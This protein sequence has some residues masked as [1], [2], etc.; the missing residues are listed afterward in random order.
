MSAS[1]FF[2]VRQIGQSCNKTNNQRPFFQFFLPTTTKL[3]V[4]TISAPNFTKSK[5]KVK[6]HVRVRRVVRTSVT[7]EV[8]YTTSYLYRFGQFN[9]KMSLVSAS[10]YLA[11]V[12]FIGQTGM[13]EFR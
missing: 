10:I 7:T 11:T 12:N 9:K 13:R 1:I 2:K 8:L 6:S 3:K 4:F 5:G